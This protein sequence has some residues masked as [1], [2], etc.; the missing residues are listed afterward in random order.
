MIK[1]ASPVPEADV[2]AAA[3]VDL[4]TAL[5]AV[6]TKFGM[7]ERALGFL[8][9]AHFLD[10]THAETLRQLARANHALGHAGKVLR[11]LDRLEQRSPD[12]KLE[13]CD[14]VIRGRSL[15]QMGDTDAARE[16]LVAVANPASRR[17]EV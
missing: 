8:E 14:Q 10:P 5:A 15:V 7:H 13:D 12:G 4:L 17:N 1:T 16:I 3:D 2:H 6:H 9:L 11:L